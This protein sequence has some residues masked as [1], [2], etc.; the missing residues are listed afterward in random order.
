MARRQKRSWGATLTIVPFWVLV[1]GAYV[2]T[3]VWTVL[4]SLTSSKMLPNTQFV[5]LAQYT[6]LFA[7]E[8]WNIAVHNIAIFGVL[9]MILCLV[10]GFLLAAMVDS[11]I[12]AEDTVRTIILYPQ[13]ISFIVT[14]LVWQWM[15]NPTVGIEKAMHDFGW[16]G[17]SFDWLVTP[18]KA[19][20]ALVLAGVW[21]GSGLIMALMLA[22]LRG[23][24]QEIWKA[25]RVDGIPTWRVY[26][27]I[28]LP[29]MRPTIVTAVVLMSLSV[30]K[31][32]DLV[33][34]LTSGGPGLSTD[35]PAKFIMD[36]F[37]NRSNIGL[38]TAACTVMLIFVL[39]VF[40][41]WFYFE[42]FREK[43]GSR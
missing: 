16:M 41:P 2:G 11:K 25:A 38:A 22:G 15:M 8:R 14:G 3:M 6:R 10:I 13:A 18:D 32:Y 21:Q 24:D 37:F 7:T 28:A 36:F 27:S 5:G 19:I 39:V 43:N 12:R 35:V 30:I 17:F 4:I 33:V 23:I 9:M 20:Y 1:L 34:A 29:M 40:T 31:A 26:V 42:Y